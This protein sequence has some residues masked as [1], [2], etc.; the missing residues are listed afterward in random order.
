M[1]TKKLNLFSFFSS[2]VDTLKAQGVEKNKRMSNFATNLEILAIILKP[3]DTWMRM[4]TYCW[5]CVHTHTHTHTHTRRHA[6]I[7]YTLD[8]HIEIKQ[9]QKY[10]QAVF[11]SG[12]LSFLTRSLL[13]SFL[14]LSLSLPLS[15]SRS[16]SPVS[17]LLFLVFSFFTASK[18]NCSSDLYQ[19][20]AFNSRIKIHQ[21]EILFMAIKQNVILKKASLFI[22]L[23]WN[24][25]S[26]NC[27]FLKSNY[28]TWLKAS[29]CDTGHCTGSI[30]AIAVFDLYPGCVSK[31]LTPRILT[32]KK[33]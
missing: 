12:L 20:R 23:W 1:P 17:F 19:A 7:Q 9:Q 31:N 29:P 2:F 14:F 4:G 6:H 30:C 18:I 25:I 13:F 16:L 26:L 32:V 28:S 3:P 15:F 24:P 21:K 5:Q 33:I 8:A 11:I 27:V 22:W 10:C